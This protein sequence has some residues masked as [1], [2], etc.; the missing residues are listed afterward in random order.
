MGEVISE[1]FICED[2]FVRYVIRLWRPVPMTFW[3]RILIVDG[4]CGGDARARS[5]DLCL[6]VRDRSCGR[7]FS[8]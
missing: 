3:M 8:W 5:R 7:T 6:R 4:G 2:I 1:W